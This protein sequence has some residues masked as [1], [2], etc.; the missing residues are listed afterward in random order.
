MLGL[1][2]Q[3][4]A[5]EIELGTKNT[6]A[7][8]I[9]SIIGVLFILFSFYS[10]GIIKFPD[11]ENNGQTPVPINREPGI[12]L[13]SDGHIG[14]KISKD[15]ITVMEPKESDSQIFNGKRPLNYIEIQ[16]LCLVREVKAD[17]LLTWH[18]VGYCNE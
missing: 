5:K 15:K 17:S 18:D 4:K 3:V 7:R 12:Y 13:K 2:G 10:A 8:F 11:N 1:I 14:D 16:N 6:I 9:S